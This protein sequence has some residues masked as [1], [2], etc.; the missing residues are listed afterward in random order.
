MIITIITLH[1]NWEP[2]SSIAKNDLPR[3]C[4]SMLGT[5]DLTD[6]PTTDDASYQKGPNQKLRQIHKGKMEGRI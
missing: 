4:L 6:A 2:L 5:L 1:S 3:L